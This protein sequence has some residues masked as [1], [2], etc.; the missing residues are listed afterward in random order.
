MG[1]ATHAV[2]VPLPPVEAMEI[3]TDLERWPAFIDGFARTV[4]VDARWPEEGAELVWESTRSGRGRVVERVVTYEAPP[5]A[6]EV[7][8]Q[9]H[10]GRIETR[11]SEEAMSGEQTVTFAPVPDG[12]RVEIALDYALARAGPLGG[13]T[14]VLFIRRALRDS[15]RR[16]LGR[17]ASEAEAVAGG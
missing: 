16:T 7:A 13:L 5:P 10:P 6:P 14:D 3:W 1:S 17:F 8:L 11:V 12:A 4:E 2:T 15:L 9:S